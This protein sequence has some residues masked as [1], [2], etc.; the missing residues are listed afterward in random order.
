MITPRIAVICGGVSA[1]REVSL[2]SG[3]SVTDV[4][5]TVYPGHVDF[6]EINSAALP[7]GLDPAVHVV[8]PVLHGTFGEDGGIQTLLEERGF[9]YA[10]CDI[11]ASQLCMNKQH[12]KD[13][14]AAVGV[15]LAP[16]ICVTAGSLPSPDN[17][18][19]QLG[20][21]LVIKPSDQGS[22]VGL[23][24]VE[25]RDELVQAL[26]AIT[27]GEWL[28]EKRIVGRET[29]VGILHGK[30]LGIV[31][32]VPVSG[33]YDYKHKYTKGMTEYRY[34]AQMSPEAESEIK[35]FAERAFAVCRCRDYARIDFILAPNGAYFLEI[36]TIPGLT[37]TSLLPKSASCSGYDFAALARAMLAPA[38]GRFANLVPSS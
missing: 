2:V 22:S 13:H 6:F 3:R 32:V 26:N 5:E 8:F 11:A 27:A 33:V 29:T 7:D 9:T 15:R 38:F 16:G 21:S 19:A 34:P 24:L 36:N 17:I 18:I 14:V 28:I 30:A 4:L 35:N 20:H 23:S 37:A 12:T 1:E 25:S 31:E 10:G